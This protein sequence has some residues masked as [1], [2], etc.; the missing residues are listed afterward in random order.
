MKWPEPL[1]NLQTLHTKWLRSSSEGHDSQFTM[2]HPSM[3]ALEN[4]MNGKRDSASDDV[5][6]T[7]CIPFQVQTLIEGR[8]SFY[9]KSIGTMVVFVE[10]KAMAERYAFIVDTAKSEE[11]EEK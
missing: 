11:F 4:G 7:N 6:S 8:S 10:L 3:Q 1:G 9:L 5:M 2:F